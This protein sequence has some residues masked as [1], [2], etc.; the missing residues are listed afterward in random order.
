MHRTW[1]IISLWFL[2]DAYNEVTGR[3][4]KEDFWGKKNDKG[5]YWIDLLSG[6]EELRKMIEEG[7]TASEI[8]ASWQEDIDAFKM[9]RAQYLLYEE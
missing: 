2:I 3:Y 6:S 1:E 8:E 4:P 7:K 9:Q 5:N